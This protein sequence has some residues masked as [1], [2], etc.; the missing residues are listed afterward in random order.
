MV[1]D[2]AETTKDYH[3]LLEVIARNTARA[4]PDGCFVALRSERGDAMTTVSAHDEDPAVAPIYNRVIGRAFQIADAPLSN[5]VLSRG[6]VFLPQLDLDAFIARSSPSARSLFHALGARGLLA[7]PLRTRGELHGVLTVIRRRAEL[8]PLD[9]LDREIAED[10]AGH[11]ALAIDN[12]RLFL[13]LQ[14]ELARRAEAEQALEVSERRRSA[15]DRAVQAS[16]FLDAIV[17][18]IPAMVFVKD[19]ERLAFVR[20]NRAGEQLLGISRDQLLGKTDFDL[21]PPDEAAFF[22]SKDRETLSANKLVE[23]PEERVQTRDGVRWLHTMK[24]PLVDADGAPRF[25]LGISHDITERK[26]AEAR[27]IAARAA[28]ESANQELESFTYSVAHD[29]RAPLRGI[30]GYSEAV[31][32]DHADLLPE[33][34][35]HQLARVRE[36]AVR[37]AL[38][39]DDLLGLAR[40]SRADL[41]RR[42]A[43]LTALAHSSIAGLQAA[44]PSRE[45]E[46]AIQPGMVVD[47]DPHLMAVVL[48]NLLENA[49]KFTSKRERAR[50]EVGAE[51]VRGVA[52]YFVRD[53]GAGFD[54][55]YADQLFG[56][57]K[58]LHRESEFPGSGIG[59]ATVARIVHRH[60]GQ[61]WAEGAVGEG[62]RFC[63]TV[64]EPP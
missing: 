1:R 44:D 23:V 56:V 46:I 45:V 41:E 12:A 2:F 30:I 49:W 3:R 33:E 60:H 15:E 5:E 29:L 32:D 13:R 53:N 47:A 62:A 63:F 18:N 10:L 52:T 21:F 61:V 7:V 38:L 20:F 26:R 37:M 42:R 11:A 14:S 59:L 36:S 6:T 39:I 8:P 34:G 43:D 51:I 50:I 9:D 57:F 27:L 58:R 28:T 25:L 24:V 64:G 19:V 4:V 22:V 48:D 31:I 35:K 16:Q 17:E 40:V 55:A 54:M